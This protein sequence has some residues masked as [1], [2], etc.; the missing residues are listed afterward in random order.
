VPLYRA[1]VPL[2]AAL[3]AQLR[4]A[5]LAMLGN[6]HRRMGDEA[7]GIY[8]A[9][10]GTDT[11]SGSAGVATRRAW[12]RAVFADL[13]IAEF[14]ITQARTDLHAS[15]LQAGTDLWVSGPWQAGVYVG[16]LDGS[17]DVAGNA[18]GLT[19]RVGSNDLRSRFLGA[20]ATWMHA[21]GWY[22]DSVL[23]AASQRYDVKPDI[24]PR[25]S[26][27][28]SSFM[29]SVEGGKAYA[30]N[31][32]WS[33]EPQAQLAWQRSSFDDLILGGA[34]VQQDAGSGWIGRLGVRIKGD[35][36][37][38]A[39]RLQPY[40]RLNFY[41]ADTSGDT[42]LFIGPSASTVIASE[43]SYTSGEV[44]AGATLALTPTASLYGEIGHLWNIGGEASV[45]SSLQGSLG[46]KVRW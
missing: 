10:L 12:A 35:L 31:E 21:G 22:V 11:A 6:L 28:A 9:G 15:G 13:N 7:L 5:D 44:A 19:G 41:H 33:I 46:I 34:R 36:A 32:R 25:A 1:E 43:N 30:L 20:Y 14:G 3:P 29:A 16:Y 40:G 37:T 8:S 17:A 45:K 24:N 18:R 26:G 2:L 4:Q 23:Q 27:K 39:G 38:G 42:A